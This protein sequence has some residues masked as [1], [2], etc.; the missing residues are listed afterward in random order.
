MSIGPRPGD[1]HLLSGGCM[2]GAVRYEV[3][4][5]FRYAMNCHCSNCRRATG[6]AFKPIAGIE[7]DRLSI[8]RGEDVVMRYG[9]EAGHDVHCRTCGSLLYSVVR[10]GR[11]VHVAMG[12]LVDDPAVRPTMH[13]FVGSKAGWYEITDDLPQHHGLP[14]ERAP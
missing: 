9:D 7:S 14:D 2:C 12:T 1:E 13:I 6:A 4:D 10:E 8:I 3:T 11:F 5:A